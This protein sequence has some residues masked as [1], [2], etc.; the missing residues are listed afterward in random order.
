MMFAMS[1]YVVA[2]LKFKDR[3]AYDR[4]QARFGRVFARFRGTLLAADDAPVVLDGA[5]PLDKLVLMSF[6]D[7]A[8]Y[9]EWAD[10]PAYREI[11]VDRIAGADS[12]ALLVRGIER[13]SGAATPSTTT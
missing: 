3:P 13:L 8:A 1:V 2:Q 9:H 10:S 11:A 5:W 6:P 4:Y 7:E 12:V